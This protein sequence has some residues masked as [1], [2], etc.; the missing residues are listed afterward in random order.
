[1]RKL[2]KLIWNKILM[3]HE[4][5]MAF[6]RDSIF[7]YVSIRDFIATRVLC[8]CSIVMALLFLSGED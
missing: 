6:K 4:V 1:M 7:D 2:L 8:G 5:R 3:I